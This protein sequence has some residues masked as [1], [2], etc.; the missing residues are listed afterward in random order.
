MKGP[1]VSLLCFVLVLFWVSFSFSHDAVQQQHSATTDSQGKRLDSLGV[2]EV[3]SLLSNWHLS[4]VADCLRRHEVDGETL[5]Y[6]DA[7]DFSAPDLCSNEE[8]VQAFH[9]KKFWR[10]LN[11]IREVQ[12]PDGSDGSSHIV[13]PLSSLLLENTR[14]ENVTASESSAEE[15]ELY[16]KR[17]LSTTPLDSGAS[18][19]HIKSDAAVIALGANADVHLA[20]TGPSQA[21]FSGTLNF[22]EGASLY[23][24][25]VRV[26]VS[27]NL[28][29]TFYCCFICTYVF[30]SPGGNLQYASSALHF[31]HASQFHHA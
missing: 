6:A 24:P 26:L 17:R 10:K 30:Y 18:G 23:L 27:N 2:T 13:V 5:F 28:S 29:I 21:N 3:Y 25:G 1:K 9:W 15:G 11:A 16:K 4:A 12:G 31:T 8:A 14:Q 22:V 7:S 20:Y 19:L